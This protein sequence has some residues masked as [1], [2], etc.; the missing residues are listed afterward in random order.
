MVTSDRLSS[1]TCSLHFVF[2]PQIL[3]CF[4]PFV[5][6]KNEH[7]NRP[8]LRGLPHMGSLNINIRLLW[9]VQHRNHKDGCRRYSG[10]AWGLQLLRTICT[11]FHHLCTRGY[12][13]NDN[14]VRNYSAACQFH[15]I[16][17]LYTVIGDF[18]VIEVIQISGFLVESGSSQGFFLMLSQRLISCLIKS[19]MSKIWN[20]HISAKLLYIQQC[21][22]TAKPKKMDLN[23]M[24]LSSNI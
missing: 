10:I 21:V 14:E 17:T 3:T 1:V 9:I 18:F 6:F 13:K 16:T 5:M 20:V 15:F 22:F 8:L 24:H 4:S 11:H 2:S 23:S 19:L 7:S 12:K